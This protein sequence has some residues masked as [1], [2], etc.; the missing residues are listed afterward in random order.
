MEEYRRTVRIALEK[1]LREVKD[2]LRQLASYEKKQV[3]S[4]NLMVKKYLA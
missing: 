2:P 4:R 3:Q 1:D